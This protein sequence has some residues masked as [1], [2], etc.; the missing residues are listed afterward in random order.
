VD[1]VVSYISSLQQPDSSFFGDK[2]GVVNTVPSSSYLFYCVEI[3]A[4]FDCLSDIDVD[5]MVRYVSSLQQPEG[6]FFVDKWGVVNTV[7]YSSYLFY[8]V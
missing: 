2:W 3:A 8:C 4:I 5:G 1:G 7:A 6:S